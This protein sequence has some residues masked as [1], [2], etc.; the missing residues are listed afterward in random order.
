M[1]VDLDVGCHLKLHPRC[2]ATHLEGLADD[3]V[4]DEDTSLAL[5]SQAKDLGAIMDKVMMSM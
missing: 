5:H 4:V 3:I 1:L 2:Q